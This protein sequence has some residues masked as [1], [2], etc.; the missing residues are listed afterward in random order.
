MNAGPHGAG[1]RLGVVGVLL[2]S[3]N[4]AVFQQQIVDVGALDCLEATGEHELF[5]EAHVHVGG[6][7]AVAQHHGGV[8]QAA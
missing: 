5:Q 6:G 4:D 7:L 2:G 3:G 8:E 1:G